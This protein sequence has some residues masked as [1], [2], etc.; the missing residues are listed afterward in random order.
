MLEIVIPILVVAAIVGG[1]IVFLGI[2]SRRRVRA[3][4][5]TPILAPF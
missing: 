1:V 5:A 4:D 2:R 3:Y